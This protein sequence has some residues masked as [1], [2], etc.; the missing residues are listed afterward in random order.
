MTKVNV[1]PPWLTH[2]SRG[3]WVTTTTGARNGG[4]SGQPSRQQGGIGPSRKAPVI[5]FFTE[6]AA[7]HR[8]GYDDGWDDDGLFNS[9][10]EGQLGG[11]RLV[12]G[13]TAI[14]NHKTDG[15]T[16]KGSSLKARRYLRARR[17]LLDRGA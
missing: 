4:G 10:G 8:H 16:L 3:W 15:R 5:L 1:V 7:G 13:N 12:Q 14:L 17:P 6:P 9:Y 2:G 11:Q